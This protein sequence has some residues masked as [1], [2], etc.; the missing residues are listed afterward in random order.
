MPSNAVPITIAGQI[1]RISTGSAAHLMPEASPIS[2]QILFMRR[3][4]SG[5]SAASARIQEN[6]DTITNRSVC[7]QMMPAFE[8]PT[9]FISA[10]SLFS[11]EM[12]LRSIKTAI[13]AVTI[14][15]RIIISR[16][17]AV[18]VSEMPVK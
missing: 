14:T 10:I 2:V 13:I 3:L 7:C 4:L 18:S 12:K 5:I 15:V 16:L 6:T 1:T 8:M 9:A 11:L 17:I